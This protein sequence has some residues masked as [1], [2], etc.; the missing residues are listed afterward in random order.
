MLFHAAFM[1]M[2]FTFDNGRNHGPKVGG[3]AEIRD[4]EVWMHV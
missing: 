4:A 1:C 3:N 2:F